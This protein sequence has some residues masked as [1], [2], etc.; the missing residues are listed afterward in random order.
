MTSVLTV[1]EWKVTESPGGE[2]QRAD[3]A[4]GWVTS[5]LI[6]AQEGLKLDLCTEKSGNHWCFKQ[7][8]PKLGFY[9]IISNEGAETDVS[10]QFGGKKRQGSEKNL[11]VMHMSL[12]MLRCLSFS[13]ISRICHLFQSS[14]I[15]WCSIILG[16]NDSS[17]ICYH[18]IEL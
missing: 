12:I 7:G 2:K 16:G 13:C 8:S 10:S 17:Y 1:F 11:C 3:D 4:I 6:S 15:A 9:W 14:C 5:L 18:E